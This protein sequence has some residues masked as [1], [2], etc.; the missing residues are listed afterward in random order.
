[1]SCLGV[2]ERDRRAQELTEDESSGGVT[3]VT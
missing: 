1:M 2:I 3:D